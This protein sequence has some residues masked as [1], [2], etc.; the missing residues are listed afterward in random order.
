MICLILLFN[1]S[2]NVSIWPNVKGLTPEDKQ[3]S[4][5]FRSLRGSDCIIQF[6][7]LKPVLDAAERNDYTVADIKNILGKP[8]V[9]SDNGNLLQYNLFPSNAGCVGLIECR[10]GKVIK[11]SMINCN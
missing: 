7:A 10:N 11:C 9:I 4:I 8:D 3:N 5:T 6:N 1:I 2:A